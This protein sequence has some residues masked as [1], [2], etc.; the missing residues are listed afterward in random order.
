MTTMRVV[1]LTGACMLGLGTV[2]AAPFEQA[3]MRITKDAQGYW[4]SEGDTR[5][6]VLSGRAQGAA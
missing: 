3:A 1:I 6:L 4:F 5:V 2:T